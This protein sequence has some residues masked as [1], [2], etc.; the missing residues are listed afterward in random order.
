MKTFLKNIAFTPFCAAYGIV[1]G[2]RN[3]LYD[4]LPRLSKNPGKITISIGGIHAGGTGKT[5]MALFVGRHLSDAGREIAFLSRGYKRKQTRQVISLPGAKDSWETVG[6]EPALLHHE[7]PRSWLGIGPNRYS[8]A[9][10]LAPLLGDRALFILDDGY[11]HRRIGRAFDIVCLPPDPFKDRL[12]PRGMLREP[13]SGLSRSSALCLIGAKEEGATLA[14][15]KN[16][17]R[18]MFPNIPAFIVHQEPA[19]WIRLET[20]ERRDLPL[21]SNPAVVCGIA[22]PERFI[23]LIKKMGIVPVAQSIFRDHH[24]FTVKEIEAMI[25]LSGAGGIVTTEKDAF[26]LQ[27][28]KLADRVD[29]WYLKIDLH[30]QDRDSQET[31]FSLIDAIPF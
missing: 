29:I 13:L 30:F 23:F 21:L 27:S 19:H 25:R 14:E 7:L 6:D 3:F 24:A 5:P 26:R 10:R 18:S 28:L 12:L 4:A 31:F 22:R 20:G 17:L 1:V 2:V 15:S 8:S 9:R 11:Q 16:R